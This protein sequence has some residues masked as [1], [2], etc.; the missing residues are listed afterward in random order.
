MSTDP[1]P[2]HWAIRSTLVAVGDLDPSV[3]FYREV[4][5]FE[6]VAREDAVRR[7]SVVRPASIHRPHAERDAGI[8]HTRHGQQW[9][10]C[11]P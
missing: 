4:G 9:L 8:H 7:F 10:G 1:V 2:R 5:P 11:G 6:E 3:A